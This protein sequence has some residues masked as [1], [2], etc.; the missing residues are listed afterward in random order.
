MCCAECFNIHCTCTQLPY[1]ERIYKYRALV[2]IAT[3]QSMISEGCKDKGCRETIWAI[4]SFERYLLSML[5]IKRKRL[6]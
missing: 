6:K 4:H 5:I 2:P 1:F 3:L